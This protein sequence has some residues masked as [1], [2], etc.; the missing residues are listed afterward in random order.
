MIEIIFKNEDFVVFNKPNGVLTHPVNSNS[1]ISVRDKLL[2]IEPSIAEW[3]IEKREGIVHRLD[4][5][6]SGLIVAALNFETFTYLQSLFKERKV[7]KEYSCLV[8]GHLKTQSG[9]IELPL[10]KSKKNR[11]KRAVSNE[12]KISTSHFEVVDEYENCT[13]LKL[14]LIHI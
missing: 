14:S 6:T 3:G 1:E 2:E 13:K 5:V 7:Y 11:T 9:V 10:S 12:G 8:E 4:K